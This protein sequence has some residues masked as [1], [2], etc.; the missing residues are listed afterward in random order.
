MG[1]N[2]VIKP[3]KDGVAEQPKIDFVGAN[4]GASGITLKVLGDSGLSFEGTSGQLFSINNNLSTGKIFSVN[5]I[6]GIPS[7]DVDADGT[8]RLNPFNGIVYS[9]TLKAYGP[10][11]GA[12]AGNSLTLTAGSGVTSGAGGSLILQAGLQATSGGDG[13]V[14]VKQVSG[15]TSN[16]QEWQNSSSYSFVQ[17][18]SSGAFQQRAAGLNSFNWTHSCTF[19]G[20]ADTPTLTFSAIHDGALGN[21][22]AWVFSSS[23]CA[24]VTL[25]SGVISASWNGPSAST[26]LDLNRCGAARYSLYDDVLINNNIYFYTGS[27]STTAIY[28]NQKTIV[29]RAPASATANIQEWQNSAGTILSSVSAAGNFSGSAASLTNFPTLNQNT[30]GTA[31]NVT[32][33]VAVANGGTNLSAIGTANQVLAVNSAGTAL[34]YITISSGSGTVTSVSGAGTVSGLTLTGTVTSSGSLTLG[35]AIGTLNQSTTGNAATVTTNANLTGHVTSVGNAAVLGSFTSAQ[36]A[37]ALTDETGTGANV[38]A[39]SPTLVTPLSNSLSAVPVASGAGNSLTIAAGSGVTSGAGANLILNPGEQAVTGGRGIVLIDG[40][41]AG[42]S[43]SS[44]TNNTVFGAGA[45]A[46]ITTGSSNTAI[47]SLALAA[48]TVASH[49]IAIGYQALQLNISGENNLAAGYQSL[50]VNNSG[51]SNTAFG[52]ATLLSSVSASGN[53]AVGTFSLYSMNGGSYNTAVGFAAIGDS[54]TGSYNVAIGNSAGSGHTTGANNT[55]VGSSS[56]MG[57]GNGAASNSIVIGANAIGNG[58]NTTTIGNTSTTKTYLYGTISAI[59]VAS[60]AGNSLTIAAGSGVTSGAG[61]SLILQAGLQATSGGDGKINFNVGSLIVGSIES[62]STTGGKLTLGDGFFTKVNGQNFSFNSGGLFSG[63]VSFTASI[64]G[65]NGTVDGPS[66]LVDNDGK[67]HYFYSTSGISTLIGAFAKN[68]LIIIGGKTSSFPGLKRSGTQIQV[69]LADDSADASLSASNFVANALSAMPVTSGAGN[70]VTIAAGAGVG[71]G[72]GG[73]LILQAGLQATSGGDGSVVIKQ[74]AGQSETTL[75]RVQSSSNVDLYRFDYSSSG[76]KV[77]SI[78]IPT[79]LGSNGSLQVGFNTVSGVYSTVIGSDTVGGGYSTVIGYFARNNGSSGVSV[80]RMAN[81]G[82]QGTAVGSNSTSGGGGVAIGY[83]SSSTTGVAM[84]YF[85]L[86]GGGIAIGNNAVGSSGNSSCVQ[87]GHSSVGTSQLGVAI[88]HASSL[89]YDSIAIGSS[90]NT[91]TNTAYGS[92]ALGHY[93][94]ATAQNQFVIK[95]APRNNFSTLSYQEIAWQ[96]GILSHLEDYLTSKARHE[97]AVFDT[98]TRTGRSIFYT[99][100]TTTAQE[101]IRIQSAVD[102]ARVAIGGNVISGTRTVIYTGLATEKGLVIQG[103]ASQTANLQ[104][105]QNSAGTALASVDAA[106]KV[107]SNALA[108]V[109]VVSGAG[110]S[111]TIAAGSGVTSGAGGS[112]ILQAGIQATSGG[113]GKVIVK[114]V[115]GQTGN[116]QEWQNSAGTALAS[117]SAAG[118]FS[119][120]GTG[121]IS[122]PF[123]GAGIVD[124]SNNGGGANYG[125]GGPRLGAGA[126]VAWNG[127]GPSSGSFDLFIA[128]DAANVLAQRNGTNAQTFRVYNTFTDASNYERLGLTWASNTCTISSEN[129]GTGTKRDVKLEG[130]NVTIN[131][132]GIGTVNLTKNGTLLAFLNDGSYAIETVS[133]RGIASSA[134]F[135]LGDLSNKRGLIWQSGTSLIDDSSNVIGTRNGT[136]AQT[137]RVYNTFTDASNYERLGLTWASNICTIGLAQNGTGAVRTLAIVGATATSGAGGNVTITAGSGAGTGAGGSLILQAGLQATS[138]GDGKVIVKQVAGQTSN[139][140]EVQNSSGTTYE[141]TYIASSVVY[142]DISTSGSSAPLARLYAGSSEAALFLNGC[143]RTI[144]LTANCDIPSLIFSGFGQP[145]KFYNGASGTIAFI[146]ADASTGVVS[147]PA[148]GV[149]DSSSSFKFGQSSSGQTPPYSYSTIVGS[150]DINSGNLYVNAKAG[151]ANGI[152]AGHNAE[153]FWVREGNAPRFF[154]QSIGNSGTKNGFVGI[155]TESPLGQL[156]VVA[157]MNNKPSVITQAKPTNTVTVTNKQLTSNVATL[158]YSGTGSFKYGETVS[159]TGVDATF[160]GTFTVTSATTTT[161]TYNLVSTDVI[162]TASSGTITCSQTANLQEWQNS[163]GTALASVD[164]AGNF[165][166]AAITSGTWNGTAITV[167]K[168]GTNLTALGTANQVLAVNSAGTALAYTT[169]ASGGTVTSVALS[170]GTTGFTVTGSPIT[171]SG[172]IT[173]AGTLAVAN[174]GTGTTTAQ[175]AINALAGGVTSAQYLRGNGTNVVLSAIQVAD[176]PTLNQNTTGSAA[177]VTTNANLTGGVTSVGN[178]ATVITNANLTGGV[179]SVG[180][181]ATVITNANLTGG[182]TSVGNAATVVTNANLTGNVT[183]VGNATT[184]ASIPAISG[185]NLTSLTAANISAGTAGIS[186][187]GNAATVTTNAN[188]TGH[189]TSVGNAAVLGSFT[190]AQLATALTDETGTGANVFATS[191]TLVTPL[192]NSLSAVPVAS[193]AGNSLT[194]AAGSGVTSGAGGSLILQAGIQA[195][196]GGDGKV[197]VKQVAGQTG[198]LQE[199]QN[200]AG[201]VLA[202]VNSSGNIRLTQSLSF[203]TGEITPVSVTSGIVNFGGGNLNLIYIGINTPSNGITINGSN[204]VGINCNPVEKLN[205]RGN[206]LIGLDSN[207]TPEGGTL[208]GGNASSGNAQLGG[209]L[210]LKGGNSSGNNQVGPNLTLQGGAST[211]TALGGSMI[212]QTTLAGSSGAVVN[213]YS[214]AMTLSGADLGIGIAV[215]AARTHIVTAAATKGLIVQGAASQ[216]ANLQEWQKSTGAMVAAVTH[217]GVFSSYQN[218][219][220]NGY[221]AMG[222]GSSGSMIPYI[223]GQSEHST[224]GFYFYASRAGNIGNI[225]GFANQF[226]FESDFTAT[227]G[228]LI[229]VN[230]NNVQRWF[231]TASGTVVSRG[232]S[233]Q[234]ANLHEWRDSTN[235]AVASVDAAGKVIS[236]AIAAIPVTSGAGNSLTI[237]AGS[238]IGT[239]GTNNGANLILNPGEFATSGTRGTVLIDGLNVGKGKTGTTNTVFGVGALGAIT[240]GTLNTAIGYQCLLANTTGTYN[241]AIGYQCL[242]VNTTGAANTA[243]GTGSLYKNTTGEGNTAIGHGVLIENTTGYQNTALGRQSL[244][245]NTT[246][247]QNIAI[248]AFSL[249]ANATGNNN[250]ASGYNALY[251]NTTGNNNTASGYRTLYSNTT[252]LDNTASG[253][254]ALYSNTTGSINTASGYGSL[255]YNT[256]GNNNTAS[257]YGSLYYNTTGNYNTASGHGSLYYNTTGNYNTA[258]GYAAGANITTG[259]NNTFLGSDAGYNASQLVSASNSMALGN[260]A[261]T[262]A[263]NQVVI[264]NTSVTQIILNGTATTNAIAA[265]PVVSGAGNSLTI[266]AGSGVTSG[267]GGSLILQAGLQATSGGDGKVIVKQVA[268]QTSNLQEWQNSAGTVLGLVTA[269]GSLQVTG[270]NTTAYN[271]T[272]YQSLINSIILESPNSAAAFSQISFGGAGGNL[273][274]QFG[275]KLNASGNGDYFWKTYNGISGYGERMTLTGLGNVGINTPSPAARTHIVTAAATKGLIVQGAASQT[276]NLQEWQ[277]SAGTVLASVSAAGNFSVGTITSGTWNGTTIAVANGGT[278]ATTAQAAINTLAGAVTSAQYLRGNGTNVVMSA[279]QVADVPTLNQNTTGTASGEQARN[280]QT[281]TSYTLVLTDAQKLL[282]LNN[283]AAI[284]VTIPTNASVAFPYGATATGI[285]V[286]QLGAGTVTFAPA[287]G[288]TLNGTPGLRTRAQYSGGTLL[289]VGENDWVIVGDTMI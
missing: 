124:A 229:T 98:A 49:C 121:T 6:S 136:N 254:H 72:A 77:L 118:N 250:T 280:T 125:F 149:F 195:T 193:G 159:V 145:T 113:D 120:T 228:N 126:F 151:G 128:R 123:G 131:S 162:S 21:R 29:F 174:G 64:T 137:F 245:F 167:A 15:Q 110:N 31:S 80:G 85:A 210:L 261:F 161:V 288:V 157:G 116:L 141:S 177:T 215:P 197:I 40:L 150:Y 287:S 58:S 83:V 27:S 67:G 142:K 95:A 208:R 268:G 283:A 143:G 275:V 264:G 90:A 133:G 160:N 12:G 234:T 196:T 92:I 181:A 38:F 284:T 66:Y 52:Y 188:L 11:S 112:L 169:L 205:V 103:A 211:G 232:V 209:P 238:G 122:I 241:T 20:G 102:Q 74:L 185:A 100:Y 17:V 117:V 192:S 180:N 253:Y 277:N 223:G 87:I 266:A 111:L 239:T 252:G 240:T 91:S 42:K 152:Q 186:V 173:L 289:K 96:L 139:I 65:G 119:L 108:A 48:N 97:W 155:R 260:G 70:S 214:T 179:T 189:V 69:R 263:S 269:A 226:I 50:R 262:T 35:G 175:L 265:V 115:A 163:A 217:T 170:G 207:T 222:T 26:M 178:A 25:S 259:S 164:A 183:S 256:T 76:N 225:S 62:F 148:G 45:L 33:V 244:N 144:K 114:Q 7:I 158:T 101:G 84:G 218:A 37:A 39:T 56:A 190:S 46:A 220:S 132:T 78:G 19:A 255:Y 279:I 271:A 212:F 99:Y 8:V 221:L 79:T 22:G 47:G 198:N 165:S 176:V 233:G 199:W 94:T 191:P 135:R 75:L 243:L 184:L 32:G 278:G 201:G 242:L 107:I 146:S 249:Q 154:V 285:D 53:V 282:T 61:G 166:V 227:T 54:T 257:G 109:P 14:I 106:G 43:K 230:N 276:A 34:A 88:G 219:V 68:G 13:K 182:V 2:I 23:G 273:E 127:G 73:S 51:N 134:D 59:P 55:L 147:L 86:A 202:S 18:N 258:S 140:F 3:N 71:T 130:F 10:I 4:A 203:S 41:N 82:E 274:N 9:N 44:G 286:L 138:G 171:T 1:Q 194:I 216:T 156:H 104:E 16:L 248:G 237:A 168:G 235:T 24:S 272:T 63:V 30:T 153:L 28:Q 200:S 60:G 281:G 224:Y 57:T 231:V 267:A 36:L 206:V 236:N 213:S 5:D 129:A 81:S 246:G 93:C 187:T 89:H 204:N 172:T 270:V 251:Y 247:S 105:W